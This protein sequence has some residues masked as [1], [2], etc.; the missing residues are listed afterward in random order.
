MPD[1][2]RVLLLGPLSQPDW[3]RRVGAAGEVIHAESWADGLEALASQD[4]DALLADLTEPGVRDSL[5][6]LRH[7]DALLARVADGVAVVDF[8]LRVRWAN[9][10]FAAWCGGSPVGR[11]FYEALG[12][13]VVAG[14][15]FCPFHSALACWRPDGP[16][17]L[18]G[19]VSV[20]SRLL[21]REGRHLEVHITPFAGA[22]RAGPLFIALGHDCT[23]VV[24]KQ[25]KLDALHR[26][27]REL[28]ALGPV[29]L[30]DLD[31]AARTD[32]LRQNVHRLARD[33]LNYDVFEI[34]LLDPATGLLNPLVQDGISA[35]AAGRQLRAG[36]EGQGVTGF[37]AATGKSY[38]CPDTL[39]DPLFLPG[40]P[41]SRS[42]LTVPLRFADQIVGTF[43]VESPTPGAF[44]DEDLQFVEILSHA[45][46]AA[47]HTLE[48]L[49]AEKTSGASESIE[50]VTREVALP[51]DD[52]LADAA[53][54][55]DRYIGHDEEVAERLRR[56]LANARLV[57]QSIAKVGE[58]LGP[59][60]GTSAVRE[61]PPP[62]FL[63]GARVLVADND[64]RV[65]R[66]AHQLLGRWGAIVETARDGQEALTL[67]RL[68]S[69]DAI[70]A[71]IRLPDLKG[72]EAFRA[73]REAQPAARVILMSGYGYDP[74]HSLVKARQ[75]GL[76]HVLF[77][78]FRVDQ[79][80]AALTNLRPGPPPRGER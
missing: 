71:D 44:G 56:V 47:L 66:S 49:D 76:S 52:V 57:K 58:D 9:P 55:L 28:T 77:K 39:A 30:A 54:V 8:D 4:Y 34:R 11:G 64:D 65:R 72:Y 42:S 73:L 2:P 74:G 15:D 50:A 16:H 43:N 53:W 79:L 3:V 67:A 36:V 33:L 26:A 78:P 63:K 10:S 48:L 80:R 13:P 51:V 61:A 6:A 70:V 35:E 32:L 31:A 40:T 27:G 17:A 69:Y 25:Q 14:E 29:P 38:L 19:P 20:S 60:P 45:I 62:P 23:A 37:V 18:R 7:A 22:R 75:E 5:R 68:A 41:G 21:I 59:R 12:S 1:L 46:A 24:Q